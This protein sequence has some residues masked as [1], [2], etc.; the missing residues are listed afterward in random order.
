MEFHPLLTLFWTYF[1]RNASE[2]DGIWRY[3]WLRRSEREYMDHELTSHT[4][5]IWWNGLEART[6]SI[7][8]CTLILSNAEM[9]YFLWWKSWNL[10]FTNRS[11][12]CK[13]WHQYTAPLEPILMHIEDSTFSELNFVGNRKSHCFIE[14]RLSDFRYC[15]VR[16]AQLLD[17]LF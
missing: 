15:W 7:Q 1:D 16:V 4:L 9:S 17:H 12:P 14:L 3:R 5:I 13:S 2:F 6:I 8:K 10:H 11:M